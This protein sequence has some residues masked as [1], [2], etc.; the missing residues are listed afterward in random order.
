MSV[1]LGSLGRLVELKCPASQSVSIDDGYS[2]QTTLEGRVK[3]QARTVRP[4][5]WSVDIGAA[6]PADLAD[7]LAF[8]GGEWGNGP[9]VWVSTDAPV[10]N[11]LTPEVSLCGPQAVFSSTVSRTGPMALGDGRFSGASLMTSDPNGT[12]WVAASKAPVPVLPG[13]PV[14]A[15]AYVLGAG[16][17]VRLHWVAADG[18]AMNGTVTSAGTGTAGTPQR[19]HAT[20]VPPVGAVSCTMSTTKALQITRPAITWTDKLF[21]WQPGEGCQKAVLHGLSRNL[22]LALRDPSYGRYSSASFTITEVG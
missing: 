3:A 7:L 17:K 8:A 15:S 22:I 4:R 12:L 20:G 9:F 11:L 18:S 10:T 16:G 21:D 14:T 5:S 1:Y 13:Q 19:L 2:F 6:T